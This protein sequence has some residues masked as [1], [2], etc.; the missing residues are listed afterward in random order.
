MTVGFSRFQWYD[1]KRQEKEWF[2]VFSI[3]T[4]AECLGLSTS[5]DSLKH[6]YNRITD[7]ANVLQ[8]ISITVTQGENSVCENTL[9]HS[10]LI[11]KKF[12]QRSFKPTF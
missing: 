4:I 12:R 8:N 7:A 10:V 3:K 11:L 6:L 5:A 1:D 2:I 9:L